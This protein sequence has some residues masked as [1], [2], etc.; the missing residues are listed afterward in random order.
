M[1]ER[2]IAEAQ[3]KAHEAEMLLANPALQDAF[4]RLEE[5]YT[6][7]WKN[8]APHRSD[9]R[10]VAYFRLQALEQLRNDLESVSKGGKVSEFNNRKKRLMQHFT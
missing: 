3:R 10:E 9:E 2:K 1:D 7:A 6:A 8:S 4:E 5:E